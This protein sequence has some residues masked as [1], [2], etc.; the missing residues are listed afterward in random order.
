M[1]HYQVNKTFQEINEKILSGKAVVVTAEEMIGIVRKHGEVDAARKVDVVTTGTFSPMCSSGAFINLGPCVP[2]IKAAKVWLNGVPAYAGLAALDVYLGGTEPRHNDP[3]NNVYPGEFLYGGGHVIQDLV[4]GK[5]INLTAESYGTHCYPS[6]RLD[7][8]VTL[9]DLPFAQLCNPRNSCQNYNCAINIT[10]KTVYTYMG[11]LRPRLGN[12]NYCT[13]G[14]L[15][16]L[17]NDTYYQTIGTGTR[18]FLGGGTGYV[19]SAGTQHTPDIPRNEKGLPRKPAG[20]L[21]VAGDLKQMH[22]RWLV[23]V[24][25]LGYGCSLSVGLGIPIP[26]LNEEM[27]MRTAIS[28]ED[29]VTQVV[30]YGHDYP[31]GKS[32]CIMEVTYAQLRSGTI[33]IGGKDVPTAPISSYVRAREIAETLKE[34]ISEGRFVLGEPQKLLPTENKI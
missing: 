31:L 22:P 9:V 12:A 20:T 3:L 6:R 34:W 24:S 19:L 25:I 29:I 5:S 11:T 7:K 18:I 16:P 4:A 13:S 2:G 17:L 32:T 27:A 14:Q 33:M 10:K 30:D 28:D 15:S 8:K 1:A 23:G 21:M 26:I